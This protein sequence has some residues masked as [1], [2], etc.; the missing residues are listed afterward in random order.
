MNHFVLSAILGMAQPT[1]APLPRLEGLA[2]DIDLAVQMRAASGGKLPFHGP[3]AQEATAL[4]LVSIAFGETGF[5]EGWIDCVEG[6]DNGRS[7][8]AF[9]LMR[10]A[11]WYGAAR[12]ELCPTSPLAAYNALR[13][14]TGYSDRCLR[15]TPMGWFYGYASGDCSKPSDA[16]RAHCERWVRLTRTMGLVGASC[17]S[18]RAITWAARLDRPSEVAGTITRPSGAV[19]LAP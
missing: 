16:G 3:A 4:A 6:G 9:Q 12:H 5:R 2:A 7:V 14:L 17:G 1:S 11:A 19:C 13:V 10:G 8:S 15:S 18:T